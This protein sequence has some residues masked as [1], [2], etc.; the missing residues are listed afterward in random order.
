MNK[1]VLLTE[2]SSLNLV[3]RR[4]EHDMSSSILG[5]ST[6]KD[7][8]TGSSTLADG[9][10]PNPVATDDPTLIESNMQGILSYL[11]EWEEPAATKKSEYVSHRRFLCFRAAYHINLIQPP[12]YFRTECGIDSSDFGVQ[13][14]LDASRNRISI[15]C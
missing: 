11:D 13:D 10:L 1:L 15:Q 8:G 12:F 2:V 6:G 14:D 5:S 4:Q 7:D 3:S 9:A